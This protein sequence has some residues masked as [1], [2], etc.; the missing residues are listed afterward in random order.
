MYVMILERDEQNIKVYEPFK[1]SIS[2]FPLD[3]DFKLSTLSRNS[4]SDLFF[5][6]IIE[7]NTFLICSSQHY[8]C[9]YF[10]KVC[11]CIWPLSFIRTSK[12]MLTDII[13]LKCTIF[14]WLSNQVLV[15]LFI[16]KLYARVN[17]FKIVLI[18]GTMQIC[19]CANDTLITC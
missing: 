9:R 14:R 13:Y 17:V 10:R 12:I 15:I 7:K 16:L 19:A 11:F 8:Y 3:Y 5:S 6:Q 4:I 1:F 2:F 18:I